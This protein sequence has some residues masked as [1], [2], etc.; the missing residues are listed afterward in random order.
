M[1]FKLDFTV[2]QY[3]EATAVSCRDGRGMELLLQFVENKYRF[4]RLGLC[5][6][7]ICPGYDIGRL[8]RDSK[9]RR[10]IYQYHLRKTL[11]FYLLALIGNFM[12]VPDDFTVLTW[13][14]RRGGIQREG[15]Q[16]TE[17]KLLFLRNSCLIHDKDHGSVENCRFATKQISKTRR[18]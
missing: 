4:C 12:M 15:A 7:S 3:R 1:V 6:L 9:V 17:S 11:G 14:E 13:D 5:S 10:N 8:E 2:A 16:K 18:R